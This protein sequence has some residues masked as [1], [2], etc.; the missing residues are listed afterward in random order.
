MTILQSWKSLTSIRYN[1]INDWEISASIIIIEKTMSRLL[2][3]IMVSIA[4]MTLFSRNDVYDADTDKFKNRL[5]L[6]RTYRVNGEEK[7]D[8][9]PSY[10]MAVYTYDRDVIV[11]TPCVLNVRVRVYDARIGD[12]YYDRTLDIFPVHVC[13][14]YGVD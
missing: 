3:K 10:L 8:T 2:I 12:V 9:L 6:T 4:I 11:E 7:V 5:T 13:G 14:F 1:N